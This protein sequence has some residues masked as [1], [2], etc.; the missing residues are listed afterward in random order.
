MVKTSLIGIRREP[1]SVQTNRNNT[2]HEKKI[3]IETAR[4]SG[5][6]FRPG[7]H[8]VSTKRN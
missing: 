6:C 4:A 2:Y 5:R 3:I 8:R 7:A 1:G